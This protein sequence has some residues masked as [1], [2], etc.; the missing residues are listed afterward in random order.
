MTLSWAKTSQHLAETL[1]HLPG[2]A[3]DPLLVSRQYPSKAHFLQ[4]F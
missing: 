1:L 3:V 2:R 4:A